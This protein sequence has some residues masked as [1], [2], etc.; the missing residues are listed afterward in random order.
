MNSRNPEGFHGPRKVFRC[1]VSVSPLGSVAS[2]TL[3]MLTCV[4]NSDM[5]SQV[6]TK[7]GNSEWLHLWTGS[8]HN[9][10]IK[11]NYVDTAKNE[12][13]GTHCPMINNTVFPPNN[14]PP[15]AV[16]IMNASGVDKSANPWASTL[17]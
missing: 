15:A 13:H 12:N 11:D 6:V 14:P 5:T 17:V 1:T 8:I 16:A 7:I 10:T 9:I 4:R 2:Y 3:F